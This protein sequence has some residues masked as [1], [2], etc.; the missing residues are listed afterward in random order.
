MHRIASATWIWSRSA[1]LCRRW[2]PAAAKGCRPTRLAEVGAEEAGAAGDEDAF[3]DEI[4]HGASGVFGLR[5]LG[6]S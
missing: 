1:F 4:G 2:L 6:F 5:F 3:A